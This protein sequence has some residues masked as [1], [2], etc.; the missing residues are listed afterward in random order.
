[1]QSAYLYHMNLKI[2]PDPY[3]FES[4]R[5]IDEAKLTRYLRPFNGWESNLHW[6]EF[7]DCGYV[8]DFR[9]Y[10]PLI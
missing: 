9:A 3:V 8:Y 6:H 10:V 2:F 1:M 4:Q 5:W 7:D